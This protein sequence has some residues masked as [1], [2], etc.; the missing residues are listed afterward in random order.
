MG[1]GVVGV[2]VLV[3]KGFLCAARQPVTIKIVNRAKHNKRIFVGYLNFTFVTSL[4]LAFPPKLVFLGRD[5]S[6]RGDSFHP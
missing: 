6:I 2:G 3:D 1:E 4:A 5:K